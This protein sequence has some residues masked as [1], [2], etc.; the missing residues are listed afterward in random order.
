MIDA[1]TAPLRHGVSLRAM[2]VVLKVPRGYSALRGTRTYRN[3]LFHRNVSWRQI[4]APH[5]GA[6]A[7][8]PGGRADELSEF[9][10]IFLES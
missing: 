3:A 1:A 9:L 7:T 2:E 8:V 5:I 10:R 6:E 4:R